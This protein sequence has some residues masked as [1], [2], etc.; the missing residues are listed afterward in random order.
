MQ[1][2]TLQY[3]IGLQAKERE[4]E[5]GETA[6]EKVRWG[7]KGREREREGAI[8]NWQPSPLSIGLAIGCIGTLQEIAIVAVNL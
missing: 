1:L 7:E 8:T 2:R 3:L 4:R 5:R 6:R